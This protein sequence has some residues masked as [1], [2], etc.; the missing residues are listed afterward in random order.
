M[1]AIV[2]I[3]HLDGR[4]VARTDLERMVT[5]LAHRGPDGAGMWY[6]GAIGLGHRM[7]WTTPESLGEKPPLVSRSGDFVLSADA[8]IDNRDELIGSLDFVAYGPREVTDSELILA[9]HE[10]WGE[11]CPKR[12]VGDFAFSIWDRPRQKL[13]CARDPVGVKPFYYY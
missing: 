6:E 4:P 2:G 8:R 5:I 10:K 11:H 3:Y 1:S 9:A 7:L 13:F 12:L